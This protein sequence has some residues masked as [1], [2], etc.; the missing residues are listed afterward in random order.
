M[1]NLF[2]KNVVIVDT[3]KEAEKKEK[4]GLPE[5]FDWLKA[6]NTSKADLRLKD[7]SMKGFDSF[8]IN[9]G[10]G[11]SKD[12]VGFANIMNKLPNLPKEMVHLFYL[13]AVPRN[14]GYAKWSKNT[15]GKD[16]KPFMAATG[17]G[18]EKALTALR[19]LTKAQIKQILRPCGGKVKNY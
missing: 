15:L 5:L 2:G 13:H 10:L 3:E 9:K 6:M 16:L 8:M 11:Q 17:L 18:K 12:T 7:P 1:I 19:V 14:R 4:S